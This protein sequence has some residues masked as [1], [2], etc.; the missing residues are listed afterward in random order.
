MAAVEGIRV[1]V[2]ISNDLDCSIFQP[3]RMK[4][5]ISKLKS[6]A[7]FSYVSSVKDVASIFSEGVSQEHSGTVLAYYC[8]EE[9]TKLIS[10]LVS[11]SKIRN[12]VTV[13]LNQEVFL[14]HRDEKDL[15]N[16][17][18]IDIVRMAISSTKKR[19]EIELEDVQKCEK[20]IAVIGGGISGIT[21]AIELSK[22]NVK[23]Y[24][25][26]KASSL[27]GHLDGLYKM[28]PLMC[29]A[30]CSLEF[31]LPMVL[32]NDNIEVFLDSEVVK[33]SG[34]GGK[35][36]VEV[37]T[38][39][40]QGGKNSQITV[41]SI[42]VATGWKSFDPSVI[43]NYKY[44]RYR[45]VVTN[46]EFENDNIRTELL[47]K[48]DGKS[49]FSVLFIQCVGSRDSRFLP[50]CSGVCCN[51]SFK[52]IEYI[53][54]K[55]PDARVFISY[56]DLRTPQTYEMFYQSMLEKHQDIVL[57]RGKPG[58]ITYNSH[59]E[60]LAVHVEDTLRNRTW[61]LNPDLIVLATGMVPNNGE[62]A[63]ILNIP[64]SGNG[65]PV[66]HIQCNPYLS[67]KNG[68]YFA[69]SSLAPSDVS[70]SITTSLGAAMKA[71]TYINRKST[72]AHAQIDRVKC[73]VCKRCI[74][75]CPHNA[76]YIDEKGYPEVSAA[77]C[78]ACGICM[79]A[80]PDQAISLITI[81]PSLVNGWISILSK[82][83]QPKENTLIIAFLCKNDAYP[84][85]QKMVSHGFR[86]PANYR[87]IPVPCAGSVNMKWIS[88]AL[89]KGLGGVLVVGCKEDQCHYVRGSKYAANRISNLQSSLENE[90][91]IG[92]HRVAFANINL[93]DED[94]LA[95][96][97]TD[98][99]E[100]IGG[101]RKIH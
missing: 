9:Q 21:A 66:N 60:G 18:A 15:A 6:V 22:N 77:G 10:G 70:S 83:A 50:Y 12:V 53:K 64:L 52:Q 59:D 31:Y 14:P 85:L 5:Y 78:E 88:E 23:V 99:Y 36:E 55:I 48:R 94:L 92:G 67:Q 28:Y 41:G 8:K 62:I 3:D 51:V 27:G 13:D 100:T 61:D 34:H 63:N 57:I 98:F 4:E 86:Y 40:S 95:Q 30:Q 38:Q 20:S 26:E 93:N 80:C 47:K 73:E 91:R 81:N 29:P 37:R 76:L 96:T 7:N 56:I 69:G 54:E 44:G 84:L 71:C 101:E 16:A 39:A 79:G 11:Q 89:I 32:N 46:W 49:E 42:I 17:K 19:A 58:E 65:F 87:I 68:I 75:E 2:Y 1:L 97:L 33:I 74:E 43:P 82:S 90:L 25:I 45:N 24:L 35:Y 72:N